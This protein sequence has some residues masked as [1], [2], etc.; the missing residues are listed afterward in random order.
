MIMKFRKLHDH[1][2]GPLRIWRE[3]SHRLQKLADQG[4]LCID[5][6]DKRRYTSCS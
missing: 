6:P 3:L 4:L 1:R 2:E 5:L